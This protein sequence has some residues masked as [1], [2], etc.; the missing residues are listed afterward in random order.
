M[1]QNAHTSRDAIAKLGKMIKGIRFAMLCTAMPDGMLRS[2]P[3]ATQQADFDGHLWFFCDADSAKVY[4]IEREHHVNLSYAD[5]NDSRYVSVSGRASVVRDQDKAREL[6]SP[7][8]KAWFANGPEDPNLAL[9]R[10]EVDQAEY[11]DAPSSTM[12]H[13]IGF[14]KAILTGHRY[15]PGEH[16]KVNLQGGA[17]IH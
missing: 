13:I 16:E 6:W 7:V 3:M 17:E 12:T 9:L 11:W 14:T 15:I 10:V 1:V 8:H 5:P 4:E 2:R